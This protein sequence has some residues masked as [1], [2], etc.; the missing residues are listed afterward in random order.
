MVAIFVTVPTRSSDVLIA[1]DA[2][3]Q[4]ERE[5]VTSQLLDHHSNQ[6]KMAAMAQAFL[7]LSRQQL[8]SELDEPFSTAT[9][10]MGLAERLQQA[11]G[12]R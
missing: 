7:R 8:L 9:V 11:K 5:A 12:D 3:Q 4:S 1:L 2:R 10:A 6:S